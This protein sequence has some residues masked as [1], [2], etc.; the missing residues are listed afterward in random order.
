MG[1]YMPLKSKM[2]ILMCILT[3]DSQLT[4][5]SRPQPCP[6]PQIT[7]QTANVRYCCL[8]LFLCSYYSLYILLIDLSREALH[9]YL[10]GSVIL[11]TVNGTKITLRR[12][13]SHRSAVRSL[14]PTGCTKSWPSSAVGFG[15]LADILQIITYIIILPILF[16]VLSD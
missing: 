14:C 11:E 1:E 13:S 15:I 8:H 7:G 10:R 3:D 12:G 4:N 6:T 16:T 9:K 5:P 2:A